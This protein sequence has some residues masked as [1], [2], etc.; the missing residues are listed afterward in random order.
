[1]DLTKFGQ[2]NNN[3]IAIQV[4][5]GSN[6]TSHPHI[7]LNIILSINERFQNVLKHQHSYTLNISN[8]LV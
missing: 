2:N 6:V 8:I 1:M 7:I 3:L 5:Q 4:S